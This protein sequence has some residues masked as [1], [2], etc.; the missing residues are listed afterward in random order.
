MPAIVNWFLPRLANRDGASK[1]TK[2]ELES[3]ATTFLEAHGKTPKGDTESLASMA[4]MW[5]V[6]AIYAAKLGEK[7]LATLVVGARLLVG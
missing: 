5:G 4:T 2:K 1:I 3:L 7:A 6:K